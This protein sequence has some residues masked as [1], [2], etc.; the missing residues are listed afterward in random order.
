MFENVYPH[1]ARL[2]IQLTW[3]QLK[4]GFSGDPSASEEPGSR[5]PTEVAGSLKTAAWLGT[6]LKTTSSPPGNTYRSLFL[7]G[8]F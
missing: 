5:L 6:H 2:P 1:E 8:P 3:T 7:A 4:G